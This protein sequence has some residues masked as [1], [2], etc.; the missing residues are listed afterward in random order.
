MIPP[1]LDWR[2]NIH[3]TG[4]WWLDNPDDSTSTKW[5][6][7]TPLLAFLA[8]AVAESKKV[9]FIGFGSIIIPDPEEVTRVVTDAVEQAGVFAIVAKGWSD[10]AAVSK[11]ASE[12]EVKE[13][14]EREGREG[15]MMSR[16]YLF[17]VKSIPHDWLFPRIDAAVHHGG[18]VSRPHFLPRAFK[19]LTQVDPGYNWSFSSR[20]VLLYAS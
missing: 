20:S 9:V 17:H 4:Y 7:P 19:I 14:E 16:P 12:D 5:T 6:P 10:R 18:A 13:A 3:V 11:D 15:E 1:P 2:E 8:L